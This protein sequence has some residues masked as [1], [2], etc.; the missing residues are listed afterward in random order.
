MTNQ[1]HLPRTLLRARRDLLWLLVWIGGLII[2]GAWDFAFLNQPA[3][4]RLSRAVL[5]TLFVGTFV[6][7][8]SCL[9]GWL[10]GIT[11]HALSEARNTFL[12]YVLTFLFNLIRSIPQIVGVLIGYVVLT[13]LI[14]ADVLRS[15]L[16]Q[17]IWMGSVISVFV[18]LE[19]SDLVRERIQHF[20]NLDFVD[21]MLCCGIKESR[22]VN[23]D[24]LFKNSRAHL[25]HKMISVFGITIFLLCSIDFI[26]S[27]GLSTDVS[28]S[29]FPMTL[30]G[31]LAKLDSKQDILAISSAF[32]D[33][34]SIGALFFEHLQGVST[35]FI[36]VF[37]LIC[38][39]NISNAFVKRHRL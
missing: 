13:L 35:A 29:N 16:S 25:L 33:F 24:I 5:N 6:V 20:K 18:F 39:Y 1:S 10:S 3:L 17:L 30:G 15:E 26:V 28:L 21:A 2:V 11:L 7:C 27:V 19:I 32:T 37:T 12:Y 31:L 36:I 22:I 9:M 4:A 23:V 34:G 14:R 8:V 38:I